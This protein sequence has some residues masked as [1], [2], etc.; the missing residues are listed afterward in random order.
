[1]KKELNFWL[2][3][4]LG[5]NIIGS[6]KEIFTRSIPLFFEDE[7]F[8]GVSSVIFYLLIIFGVLMI[9]NIKR[10]GYYIIVIDMFYNLI[11]SF[12]TEGNYLIPLFGLMLFHLVLLLKKDGVSAYKTLNMYKF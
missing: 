9:Y 12:F 4:I 6:L 8:L 7:I 1:M 11:L 10:I 3:L 2:Q 5:L